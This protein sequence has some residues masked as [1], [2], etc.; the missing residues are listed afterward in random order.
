[1]KLKCRLPEIR[2]RNGRMTLTDVAVK[3]GI[4]LSTLSRVDSG[5]SH[6]LDYETV[7]TLCALFKIHPGDL[8][9]IVW[10]EGDQPF[11]PLDMAAAA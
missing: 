3:T 2:A 7:V 9:E 4:A 1:M 11:S 10:E 5:K 6:R 8:F